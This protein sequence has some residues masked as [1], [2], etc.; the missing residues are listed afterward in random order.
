MTIGI[1]RKKPGRLEISVIA[2]FVGQVPHALLL[3]KT[4]HEDRAGNIPKVG[5]IRDPV[6]P[7]C[8]LALVGM[9]DNQECCACFLAQADK[10]SH[11]I[12][13]CVSRAHV[14]HRRD[15]SLQGIKDTESGLVVPHEYY[16]FD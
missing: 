6:T 8:T 14:Q 5:G 13:H 16:S 7:A 1:N 4:K 2:L 10:G 12:T 9:T 3:G 15:K 11:A